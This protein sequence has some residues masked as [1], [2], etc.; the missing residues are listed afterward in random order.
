MDPHVEG[1]EGKVMEL[2]FTDVLLFIIIVILA[3]IFYEVQK[4]K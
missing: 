1:A 4:P 3:K 2:V